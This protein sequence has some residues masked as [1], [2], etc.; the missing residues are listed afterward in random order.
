MPVTYHL[1]PYTNR[2]IFPPGELFTSF[3]L[4]AALFKVRICYY[5]CAGFKSCSS[6]ACPE[7]CTYILQHVPWTQSFYNFDCHGEHVYTMLETAKCQFH[8]CPYHCP[9]GLTAGHP[10]QRKGPCF[11]QYGLINGY[12]CVLG[13]IKSEAN[14]KPMQ[15]KPE[16][17]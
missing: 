12:L 8:I 10:H 15:M 13:C 1:L 11:N 5:K 3:I 9:H 2:R 16:Q 14:Y 7:D 6:Q 17:V 4:Y